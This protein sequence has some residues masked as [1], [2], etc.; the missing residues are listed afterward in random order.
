MSD[1]HAFAYAPFEQPFGCDPPIV[2][3][4]ICGQAARKD[5]EDGGVITPCPHLAFI[6]V[7]MLG[8]YEYT[9]E[10]FARRLEGLD[11]EDLEE[12]EELREVLAAAGY[13][14]QLLALEVTYGGMGCG[15]MWF[16]DAFG[17]DY[18]TLKADRE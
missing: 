8:D 16:T 17:F 4:P 2:H 12:M 3:C 6:Y 11:D 18:S 14:N 5:T 7:G 9:S 1:G 10:D 13:G 15:P